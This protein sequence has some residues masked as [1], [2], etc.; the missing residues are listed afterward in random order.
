M[1]PAPLSGLYT[2]SL[3]LLTDLYQLTMAYGYWQQGLQDREA[4]FHLYFRRP[5]F[6]GGY[7]VCAGLAYAVDWLQHLHFSAD[8]LAYLGSLQ[9]SKG[10]A[11]FDPSFLEYLRELK[12]TCDVDAIA[13]GT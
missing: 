2:P 10:A 13:E 5:P 1:N 4:V 7:A 12:F 11:L 8:D 6:E 3:S 9:D